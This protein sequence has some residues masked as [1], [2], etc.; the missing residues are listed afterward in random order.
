MKSLYIA[1]AF[2]TALLAPVS[3][4]E[5]PNLTNWF[6]SAMKGGQWMDV[7]LFEW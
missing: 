6:E 7:P 5:K 2:I 1:V 4:E 3:A